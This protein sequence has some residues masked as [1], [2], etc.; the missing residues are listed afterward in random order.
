[1]RLTLLTVITQILNECFEKSNCSMKMFWRETSSR[2][3]CK[4]IGMHRF[5]AIRW[6]FHVNIWL[7]RKFDDCQY[8][9]QPIKLHFTLNYNHE[10]RAALLSCYNRR[11][12]SLFSLLTLWHYSK[13]VYRIVDPHFLNFFLVKKIREFNF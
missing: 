5:L 11:Q 8:F 1:M 3:L 7:L 4:Y 2:K 6:M 9:F 10:R 13:L 12:N